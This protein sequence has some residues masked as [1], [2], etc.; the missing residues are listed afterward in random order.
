LQAITRVAPPGPNTAIG[1]S[2][3]GFDV[4]ARGP[5]FEQTFLAL[6]TRNW[7]I[8]GLFARGLLKDYTDGDQLRD[9]VFRAAATMPCTE[10]EAQEAM[11]WP[12][13]LEEFPDKAEQEQIKR[14]SLALD[15]YDP[16][17]PKIA[18]KF[19]AWMQSST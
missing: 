1:A 11:V 9:E 16:E 4:I 19:F 2:A 10:H 6:M 8:S 5:E 3:L 18:E 12:V 15:G 14:K 7:L 13:I 17:K